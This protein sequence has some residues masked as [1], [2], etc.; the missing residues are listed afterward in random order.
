MSDPEAHIVAWEAAGLI[1]APLAARL[2]AA[3]APIVAQ[4]PAAAHSPA[5]GPTAASFFGPVVTIGEVFAYLGLGF[6]LGAWVAFIGSFASSTDREAILTAGLTIAALAT[7]GLGVFLMRGDSRRRRGAGVAFLTTILLAAA[8]AEFLVQMDFLRNTFQFQASAVLV[9]LIAVA[10]AAGMRRI[11]PAVS[12]QAGL[13]ITLAALAAAVLGWAQQFVYPSNLGRGPCCPQPT[14]EPVAVLVAGATW[15]LLTALGLGL[16]AIVEMRTTAGDPPTLRR[17][18]LTRFWAGM[19]AVV[20]VATA[21]TQSGFKG[22]DANAND[23]YGRILEPWIAEAVILAVAV[24]LAERAFRR[25]STAFILAAAAGLIIALTD[26]NFTYLA[27]STYIGLLIEGGIL[28]IVGFA[29]DRLRRRLSRPSTPAG[30]AGVVSAVAAVPVALPAESP[31]MDV[32]HEPPT[33]ED[34]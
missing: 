25:N 33:I 17:V 12:T 4:A 3:S 15:W 6:L 14:V 22:T 10:V 29:G 18:G 28:L 31:A 21:L 1:D 2:R 24:I 16:L 9:A 26:F 8:A 20:G 13:L 7:F 19:V 23:V 32:H 27:Q 34:L 30:A 11:L 5:A